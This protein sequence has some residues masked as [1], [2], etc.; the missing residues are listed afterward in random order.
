MT[1]VLLAL[2]A[3]AAGAAVAAALVHRRAAAALSKARSD[4]ER[5]LANASDAVIA[6]AVD[7]VTITAWNPAAEALFGWPAAEVLG[8]QLPTIGDDDIERERGVVLE[9]VRRGERVSVVTRRVHRD[10]HDIDVRINY[11]AIPGPDGGFGGWMGTVTDVTEE[12]ALA[13]E[14]AERA[15]LVER[16]NAVVADINAELDVTSVLDRLA[17]HATVL[18]S[19]DGAGL[20]LVD[21]DSSHVATG[22]G[23]LSEWVGYRFSPGE[24]VFNRAFA[25]NRQ[26]VIEDY[27]A[28]P[29][30]MQ[31][32]QG[33]GASV[34]TPISVR[35]EHI[36]SL[37]VFF[38]A[39]GHRPSDAQ[40][41]ILRLLAGHAGTAVANARAYGA[42][43]RGRAL[44]QEVLDRLVD[45]VAVLDDAGNVMRWNRSAAEL[46]GV[47]AGE[48]LGRPFPWQTGTRVE[49][50]GHRLR[51]D[52]WMETIVTALPESG[53]AMVV[54]RDVSRHMALQET[55]ALLFAMASHE[56]R[57]PLTVI[58]GYARR[59][60]DRLETMTVDEQRE[61]VEA[62]MR[63]AGVLER[64]INQLLAGSMAELGRLEVDPDPLDLAPLLDAATGFL[65]GTTSS[66]RFVVD[67]EDGL[68]IVLAD[69][70]AVESVLTQLLENAVKYSPNG[71]TVRVRAV[72][73]R[74]E[75]E[76]S[77]S[78]EG[79]G[80]R[81]GEEER[82]FDRFARGAS[83]ARGT[84]LGLFIVQRL[85]EAQ[86]GR[87]WARRHDGPGST[88]SFSLP[89]S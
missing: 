58:G 79:I 60:R 67:V 28:E 4:A 8:R 47:L 45:G 65:A 57:T 1:Q 74:D 61:S 70:H 6:C 37:G 84:G 87:V 9:R 42:M 75:V 50:A 22:V 18:C 85:V 88:F 38:G 36:G 49:P 29:M 30:R 76:V 46:T 89:R 41:E 11:S 53:G 10:G 32:L 13:A 54:M 72:A 26:L 3:A 66:H 2:V 55:K 25:Q 40:L 48:V 27:D 63:K 64:T 35:G 69:E 59:L 34:I 81:P 21:D 19:A 68:P 52:C 82:V 62:I 43:A 7:G 17:M 73:G 86:G 78:D 71:T 77:V 20:T 31:L 51:D 39:R 33:V 83:S 12:M 56:L 14:R 16:L 80:L 15:E 5:V 44:A 24:G 23:I